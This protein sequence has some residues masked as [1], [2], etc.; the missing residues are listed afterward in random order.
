MSWGN[1]GVNLRASADLTARHAR[2]EVH[3]VGVLVHAVGHHEGGTA[4]FRCRDHRLTVRHTGGNGLFRE[5]VD[6]GTQG[7]FGEFAVPEHRGGDADGIDGAAA[8]RSSCSP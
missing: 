5:D 3:H 1:T 4:A 2:S 7:G 6:P 8:S